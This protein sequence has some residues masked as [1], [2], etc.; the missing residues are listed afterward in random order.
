MNIDYVRTWGGWLSVITILFIA[1]LATFLAIDSNK[2]IAF[3][4]VAEACK[5]EKSKKCDELIKFGVSPELYVNDI[6]YQKSVDDKAIKSIESNSS[7]AVPL[8]EFTLA[9]AGDKN[10]K[11][12]VK[13]I[14]ELE[15][16]IER[17]K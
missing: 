5:L 8:A 16:R 6:N 12:A 7:A 11:L 3:Q 4:G 13:V 17:S 10:V 14:E 9:Y 1:V 15:E 2:N